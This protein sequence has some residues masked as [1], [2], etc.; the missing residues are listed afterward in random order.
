MNEKKD[1]NYNINI[2][3][4]SYGL[5]EDLGKKLENNIE[6]ISGKKGINKLF[7]DSSDVS[8]EESHIKYYEH[9][10]K[11]IKGESNN[12]VHTKS[13]NTSPV[14]RIKKVP[15]SHK[16]NFYQKEF[17]KRLMEHNDSNINENEN[18]LC[19]QPNKEILLENEHS[20]QTDSSHKNY[21]SHIFEKNN[22]IKHRLN[23]SSKI[24]EEDEEH[25]KEKDTTPTIKFSINEISKF[26]NNINY[27]NHDSRTTKSDKHFSKYKKAQKR[28]ST[29]L[30]N[31]DKKEKNEKKRK[32]SSIFF[33][34]NINKSYNNISNNNIE[35]EKNKSKKSL[36]LKKNESSKK[37]LQVVTPI[38]G[39]NDKTYNN[40]F[41]STINT[42]NVN[43]LKIETKKKYFLCCIPIS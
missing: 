43:T 32:K 30:I 35:N 12:D 10:L 20:N 38:V 5:E 1:N 6:V 4:I 27:F 24:F 40:N 3:N 23:S 31:E 29:F 14:N 19:L 21:Y 37:S 42:S 16:K 33:E 11:S 41:I 26:A 22:L 18:L 9:F 8:A 36:K 15:T 13:R 28:H 2:Y 25:N 39:V 17:K 34:E 7:V